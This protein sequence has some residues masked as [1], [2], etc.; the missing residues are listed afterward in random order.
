GMVFQG[1]GYIFLEESGIKV[2]KDLEGKSFGTTP[3]DFGQVLL[4][5]LGAAAGFD[6]TKVIIKNIDAAVRTPAFFERKIDFLAGARGSSVPRMAIVAKRQN[7][8]IGY[9]FFKDMGINSYGHVIQVHEERIKSNP[10]QI[11]RFM[12]ALM[13]AWDWSIKNP[14]QALEVF[15]TANPEKDREITLAEMQDGLGDI[16]DPETKQFGLGYM[17]EA[18][19]KRSA[20]L[21][22]KYAG[23][24]KPVNYQMIYTNQFI[25]KK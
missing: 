8:K 25:S 2:P 12:A 3:G 5:A 4:P 13:D 10:D 21:A 16:Q 17:K 9:L 7:K 14:Q 24:E 19:M 11:Q 6:H 20:E 1:G 18:M 23:L 15:M 22:N